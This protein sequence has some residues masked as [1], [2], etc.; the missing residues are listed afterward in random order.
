[1]MDFSENRKLYH[2]WRVA[3]L[4]EKLSQKLFPDYRT[5]MFYAGLLHDIG[6]ISLPYH[7][8]HY[9]KIEKPCKSSILFNHPQK[10]ANIVKNLGFLF[11]ASD[12][13]LDHHER[14]DGS[15]YPRGISGNDIT[16]GGQILRISDTVDVLLRDNFTSLGNIK[17]KLLLRRGKEFSDKIYE[18]M[19]VTLDEN[20]F[21][22]NIISEK[23]ISQILLKIM[24]NLPPPNMVPFESE[25]DEIVKVFADVIDAKHNYTAG[26]SK[27]VAIYTYII[28]KALGI[29]EEQARKLKVAGY[30]HD[31]GKVAIPRAILDKPGRLTMDE[32]KLIKNH[33]VFTMEIMS[34]IHCL[35][36]MVIIAGSHHERY[37]GMGYPGRLSRDTIPLGGRI[38]AIADAYDAM[39]SERPYQHKRNSVEAKDILIKNSR[40]QFDPEIVKVAVKVLP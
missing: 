5:E 35:K 18:A 2:A 39:T 12:I 7:I 30:L 23:S 15:G 13:I 27:R 8:V 10:S 14:W 22:D 9:E 3:I 28:A 20:D 24:K 29:P 37:D 6:A 32:Y 40:S 11:L 26:H 4:S 36:D 1:M 31:A 25:M 38:M 21:F 19:E 34:M 33:P 16:L 17:K